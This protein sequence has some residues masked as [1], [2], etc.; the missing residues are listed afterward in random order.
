MLSAFTYLLLAIA[1]T[2]VSA[3]YTTL[4]RSFMAEAGPSS[5]ISSQ[6]RPWNYPHSKDFIHHLRINGHVVASSGVHSRTASESKKYIPKLYYSEMFFDQNSTCTGSDSVILVN[7]HN[8]HTYYDHYLNSMASSI[9]SIEVVDDTSAVITFSY[10][11]SPDCVGIPDGSYNFTDG[12][13][14]CMDIS[15]ST[16]IPNVHLINWSPLKPTPPIDY[17]TGRL[18]LYYYSGAAN[19]LSNKGQQTAYY[20][21]SSPTN[22]CV[23]NDIEY[24]IGPYGNATMFTCNDEGWT[25][26]T[27]NS[28]TSCTG[29]VSLI[30]TGNLTSGCTEAGYFGDIAYFGY[31]SFRCIP[32]T[33]STGNKKNPS[34]KKKGTTI[35]HVIR[36]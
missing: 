23:A 33:T 2:S 5:A 10:W 4:G 9:Q 13:D 30:Y 25:I 20:M 3:L 17:S 19:C 8:C 35:A 14:T 6:N 36:E 27:Y 24:T 32:P 11:N 18:E 29:D 31:N 7:Y 1:S 12:L 21:E 26:T 22:I 28:L 34:L 15:E 16:S